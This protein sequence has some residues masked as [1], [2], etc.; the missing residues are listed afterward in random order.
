MMQHNPI[1]GAYRS[2]VLRLT[3]GLHT[4][5]CELEPSSP[6]ALLDALTNLLANAAVI[7]GC[8]DKAPGNL[9]NAIQIKING[10]H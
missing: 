6:Q 10:A 2:E 8:S 7:A 4:R 3:E 5:L 9:V 1:N